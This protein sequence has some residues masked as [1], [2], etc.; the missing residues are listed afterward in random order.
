MRAAMGYDASSMDE[1]NGP[2]DGPARLLTVLEQQ[3]L[4]EIASGSTNEE[5]AERL[6]YSPSYVKDVVASARERLGARDRA[7]AAALAVE[8]GI[9]RRGPEGRFVASG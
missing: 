3:V 1:P 7:H 6:S 2:E 5:I 9:I 8:L 4:A